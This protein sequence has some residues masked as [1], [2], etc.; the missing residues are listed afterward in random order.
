MFCWSC[1]VRKQ[2]CPRIWGHLPSWSPFKI[3]KI[4]WLAAEFWR[5][6]KVVLS[7]YLLQPLP[8]QRLPRPQYPPHQKSVSFFHNYNATAIAQGHH[9]WPRQLCY[10][11]VPSP[12]AAAYPLHFAGLCYCGGLARTHCG[13]MKI[14]APTVRRRLKLIPPTSYTT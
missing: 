4:A 7:A 14:R 3:P 12:A 13:G 2:T 6:V 11:N 9:P 1:L 10:S 8:L 5:T